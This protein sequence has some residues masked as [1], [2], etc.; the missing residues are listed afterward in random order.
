MSSKLRR[1][2]SRLSRSPC[3]R[4]IS[5]RQA[6][7]V[8]T[9]E[10]DW[11]EDI[12]AVALTVWSAKRP[13]WMVLLEDHEAEALDEPLAEIVRCQ[14]GDDAVTAM[15]MRQLIENATGGRWRG[16]WCSDSHGDAG[17]R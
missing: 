17:S 3:S 16:P 1:A 2:R 15:A 10:I 14:A 7:R 13:L 8:L 9:Y 5:F 6:G 4:S 12:P 11:N